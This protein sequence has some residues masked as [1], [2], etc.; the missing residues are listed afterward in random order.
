MIRSG[1]WFG[2]LALNAVVH[3]NGSRHAVETVAARWSSQQRSAR[4]SQ[5]SRDWL[6]AG[7]L[8]AGKELLP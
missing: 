6:R 8:I 3:R 5:R 1:E 7:S 4:A 2:A